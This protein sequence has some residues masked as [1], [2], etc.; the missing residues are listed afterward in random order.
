MKNL[1]PHFIQK[2]YQSGNMSGEFQAASMFVDISGFT[3]TT[4]S[5]MKHGKVGAEVLSELLK[6]Y[7]TPTVQVVYENG[8]FIT[9]FAGD[10]FTALF[11][12]RDSDPA[13]VCKRVLTAASKI[14]L[15]F[16]ENNVYPSRYGDFDFAVKAG[17]GLGKASWG[18]VGD[19]TEKSYYFRDTAVDHCAFAEHHCKQGEIWAEEKIFDLI[20]ELILET[21]QEDNFH[22]IGKINASTLP[23][24]LEVSTQRISENILAKFANK[25]ML[26]FPQAEFRR[27]ISVFISFS[28]VF[29]MDEFATIALTNIRI[30]GGCHPRL[31]FGD[32]GG[33]MLLFFGT[34]VSH[35]NDMQRAL[36]FILSFRKD[37]QSLGDSIKFRAGV[38]QGM[39]Y[40]GFYGSDLRQEFSCLGNAVNQSARF[41]MKAEWGQILVDSV[42]AESTMFH[43]NHIGD[44]IFKGRG[45]SIPTYEVLGKA[46]A[47]ETFFAGEMV[48]RDTELDQ[49]FQ[50]LEPL[51]DRKFGG[52]VYVDGVAGMGKSRLVYELRQS[53]V[54]S[55]ISWFEMPCDE[56]LR[57]SFNPFVY[58]MKNYFDQSEQ[59]SEA[60]NKSAFED[61]LANLIDRTTD[62]EVKNE[63]VRT[64]S[65]LGAWIDL[66]WEDSL[67]DQLDAKGRY[68][69]ALYGIKNF[70]KA[71]SLIQPVIIDIEDGHWIDS[72][73]K[74]VLE[75]LTRNVDDFPFIIVSPCRYLDDDSEYYFGL[76]DVMENR[77][78]L[79]FLSKE[80]A[81]SLIIEYLYG[82][83]DSGDIS[84]KTLN[85]TL[86]FIFDKSQGNPFYIEQII[87]YLKEHHLFDSDFNL[88][89]DAF[90]IPSGINSIIIARVDRLTHLVKNVIKAASVIGR[91]F[92]I[93]ILSAVL[94]ADVVTQIKIAENG[95]IWSELNEL[96]YLFK[97]ALLKEAV[98]E[99]QLRARLRELHLLT[100]DA[101][102]KLYEEDISS[103]YGDLAYH[104]EK[105]EVANKAIE[106]LE[107]AG[108]YSRANYQNQLA[109]GFYDR[110]L[111]MLNAQIADEESESIHPSKSAT[112]HYI[113][114]LI[115]KGVILQLIGEWDACQN[116]RED[117]V[118]LAEKIEDKKRIASTNIE[119]GALFQRKGDSERA[120][121]C[122]KKS[123]QLSEELGNSLGIANAFGNIGLVYWRK[124]DYKTAMN[125]YEKLLDIFYKLEDT[126]GV[127][128]AMGNM[129]NVRWNQGDYDAAM[130]CFEKQL[131]ICRELGDK[132]GVSIAT[133]SIGLVYWSKGD[134][135]AAIDSYNEQLNIC[136]EL[137]DKQSASNAFGN[138][139]SLHYNKGDHNAAMDCFEKQLRICRELG[140]KQGVSNAIGS[141]GPIFYERGD[142][143]SAMDCFERQLKI[144]RE[145]GNKQS[146]SY[147][148]GNMGFVHFERG[149][150][151]AAMACYEEQ[152][153]I[154]RELG[155]KMGVSVVT[156]NM[157][158]VHYE[159]G[160]SDA[161]MESYDRAIAIGRELGANYYLGLYVIH[162]AQALYAI[163]KYDEARLLGSEGSRLAEEVGNKEYVFKGK[164]L[165]AKID[166]ALGDREKAMAIL[167]DMLAKT[168][169]K[170][171]IADL[172][173]ELRM[174]NEELGKSD[175]SEE[176]RRTA[177][178]LY[179]ELY[180]KAPKF[181]Y[182]NRISELSEL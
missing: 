182:R 25:E 116:V 100:A 41:M 26:T 14:N 62:E 113:D 108:D 61:K 123:L 160:D 134:F 90:D 141:M 21:K 170:N 129:G 22:Q 146:V 149:D 29:D 11:P 165:V 32:K 172:N 17:L 104:Y 24:P 176:N 131:K 103:H 124:G 154:G 157:G 3:K 63:L 57:K 150:Y 169:Q 96:Q 135:N 67:Y 15:F 106:Y 153:G 97:H 53:L 99:M 40:T 101:I 35:E 83:E 125:Y 72:D 81:R 88:I 132:Q 142:Y 122:N 43:F 59:M 16:S 137:G 89:E 39:M 47:T 145:L 159:K 65:I 48:G 173:Y 152:L 8:G 166:F 177:L 155:D 161:A 120:M 37:I 98:Y 50:Y 118:R 151:D 115:K 60:E 42:I 1:I 20:K 102:E 31:D 34:P 174:R 75:I 110:L 117:A 85:L 30:Y 119:L 19:D 6:Y 162:K 179:R 74:K 163:Q 84:V 5:L 46:S 111:S 107:K 91:E 80:A 13:L 140:Y 127:S 66:Y 73:S 121:A 95:Q 10:A 9:T 105:A 54:G 76:T 178:L 175:L 68:E 148:V 130:D 158:G 36:D 69:N 147:A 181:V 133:G 109:L 138:M 167:S 79:E 168:E 56:I 4:E 164:M 58:F 139:G 28:N 12:L 156:D 114:T 51:S 55:E 171:D 23:Q 18:I 71:E 45:N 2:N 78:K 92:E 82:L 70:I 7:F 27:T 38:T 64:K 144:C 86:D 49:L 33:N 143:D 87:L 93:K 126:R 77:I 44:F 128:S 52:I 112:P 180:E 136:R 94:H